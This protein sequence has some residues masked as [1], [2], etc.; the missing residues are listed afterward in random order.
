MKAGIS[1]VELAQKIE[2]RKA[3]KKDFI[4][5]TRE[6]RLNAEGNSL[7]INGHTEVA[8]TEN[9]HRQIGDRLGIPGRY[10][11]RMRSETPALLAENVNTWFAK[12]PERRMV[13]TL[14]P[15]G[16]AFLSDRYLRYENEDAMNAVLPA[17]AD[18]PGLKI[19]S[20][21][22]TESRLYIKAI[23][24]SRQGEVKVGDVVQ[25]GVIIR[26]S[27]IGL[28]A[29][30]AQGFI[31]KLACL[32]GM[33]IPDSGFRQHHV[34][35]R[36]VEGELVYEYL[37]DDT[38][39]ADDH[40][41]LLKLRDTIKF[42]LSQEM[43]DRVLGKLRGAAEQRLEGNPAKAIEVL[44]KRVGLLEKEQG[45][46]LR[47]LIEGGDISRWGVA[48]AV[49]RFAQDPESYDRATE[50]EEIGGRIIDLPKTDWSAIAQAA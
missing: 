1:L 13:R 3:L 8:P 39:K 24:P 27:E 50:L 46:V 12:K 10:Y 34:G 41:T 36:A 6:L 31:K 47:Y 33:V 14:G 25:A 26:N 23:L 37:A 42:I 5:D 38:L 28:G 35:S 43:L 7:T 29:I 30:S 32:N 19:E 2:S 17:F 9:C 49:T 22:L 15:A 21:D 16:R 44:G 48:N 20:C 40:A 11:D 18:Y 4:A 45:D